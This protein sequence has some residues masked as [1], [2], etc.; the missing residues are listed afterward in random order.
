MS[1]LRVRRDVQ[2]LAGNLYEPRAIVP[3]LHLVPRR[4]EL[5]ALGAEDGEQRRDVVTSRGG[6]ELL[7][8]LS[9]RGEGLRSLWN[10]GE[11]GRGEPER[12]EGEYHP[13]RSHRYLPHCATGVARRRH[14]S[15]PCSRP[16]ASCWRLPDLLVRPRRRRRCLPTKA[17]PS[18]YRSCRLRCRF[19]LG[20]CW[21]TGRRRKPIPPDAPGPPPRSIVDALGPPRLFPPYLFAVARSP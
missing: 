4:D 14:P 18:G 16:P 17:R 7:A 13:E 8:R 20:L 15:S 10:R 21:A 1:A 2:L 11:G 12:G 19:W 6:D 5:R 3:V 9:W